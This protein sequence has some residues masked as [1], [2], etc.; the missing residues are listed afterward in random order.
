MPTLEAI[1][2]AAE[3]VA[4]EYPVR[5]IEL[6]GS[7]AEGTA[8]E[9]IDID[10]LVECQDNPT[11]LLQVSGVREALSESLNKEV[12]VVKLPRQANDGLIIHH[13]VSLYG[14]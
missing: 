9:D 7:Y 6:F 14:A 4:K 5:R 8:D 13:T 2:Q 1:R 3:A 10:F 11:S 12:D